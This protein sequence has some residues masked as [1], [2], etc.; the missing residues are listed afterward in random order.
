MSLQLYVINAMLRFSI[1]RRF[2]RNP[3]V[4]ELRPIMKGLP[5]AK[6]PAQIRIEETRLG[7][8]PT[9][10]VSA[11]GA[12]AAHAILYIHGGGFVGGSPATHRALTWRLAKETGLPVYAIDYR[13]APEHPFPAGL[14]DCVTAYRTLLEKGIASG[15]IAVGGDSAGGNLTL[16][17]ALKLKASGLPQP[18]ALVCLSP[19][20]DL[21][22]PAPSHKTNT[23]SDAMFDA[24]TFDT[25]AKSYCPGHDASDPLV[26]PRRGDVAGLPPTLFQA[27]GAEM[28]RDDSVLMADRMRAAGVPVTIEIW[29][30]VAHVWQVTADMLPEGRA[31]IAKIAAFIKDK[32]KV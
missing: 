32:L 28:L 19:V 17:L 27:S 3:D 14:E 26:S 23:R 6:V 15:A 12:S 2:R 20:T 8:V 13:L 21:S 18:A 1:K 30:K 9:E 5:P 4:M 29:P 24:R 7:N 16:A 25:V 10:R 31:A 11:A 22:E